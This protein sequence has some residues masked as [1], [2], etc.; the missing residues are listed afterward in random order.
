MTKKS[1]PRARSP[2][3]LRTRPSAA[4]E[5]DNSEGES[6]LSPVPMSVAAPPSPY[7]SAPTSPTLAG[8]GTRRY[9]DV[10]R[11]WATSD[12]SRREESSP[13]PASERESVCVSP[14]RVPG[15]KT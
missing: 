9:S 12:A 3:K 10:V 14:S 8:L 11:D 5:R 6:E 15:E 4:D 1:A 2:Y 7:A 13:E